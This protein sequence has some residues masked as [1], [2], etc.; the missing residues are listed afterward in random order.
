MRWL[1]LLFSCFLLH[2]A[3]AQVIAEPTQATNANTFD[4]TKLLMRNEASGSAIVHSNGFGLSYRRGKHITGFS[5]RVFEIELVNY[6]H[7]KEVKSINPGFDNSKGY[8]YGKLNSYF[9][10]RPGI[11]YQKVIYTKPRSKGVEVR[12]VAFAGPSIGLAKPVYLLI[13]TERPFPIG[14][15][16]I[17]ERYDPDR[18]FTDN[19]VGRAPFIRGLSELSIHPGLYG[20]FGLNF[21]YAMQDDKIRAVE[22]GI[23]VDAYLKKVPLMANEMNRRVLLTV[24]LAFTYGRKWF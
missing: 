1:A 10:I 22:T 16:V 21:E 19:I 14:Y 15:D 3:D 2:L 20:R 5:K 18:H 17:T 23:C 9:I 12:Y 13:A 6:R 8:F 24:Y 4:D 11:G 7:P